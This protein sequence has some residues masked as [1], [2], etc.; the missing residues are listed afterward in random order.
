MDAFLLT[1]LIIVFTT[2]LASYIRRVTKDKCLKSFE[3]YMV[4]IELSDGKIYI[5]TLEIENTGME[6][7]YRKSTDEEGILKMSHIL[8]KEEY[9]LITAILRYHDQLTGKNCKKRQATL[10]KTYH[11]NFF[12]RICRKLLNFIKLIK[13]SLMEVATILSGKL[14]STNPNSFLAS[15]EKYTNKLNQE[16]VNTIDASYDPLLEKYIGHIVVAQLKYTDKTRFLTGILKDYT[17]SF[18]EL[19]EVVY[20]EG[21]TCDMVLP[22]RICSVKGLSESYENNSIF[23]FDFDIK[24]YKKFF[25]LTNYKDANQKKRKVGRTEKVSPTLC[26]DN[27]DKAGG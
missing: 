6:V 23:T 1:V 15:N 24:K 19:L 14:K 10:K 21:R 9:P 8:Y 12:R 25:S 3:G 7:I 17:Q 13:D 2:L 27:D 26:A 20:T 16:M 4:N 11:P 18:I 22:R 5:G